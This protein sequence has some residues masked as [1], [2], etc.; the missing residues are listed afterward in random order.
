MPVSF[1]IGGSSHPIGGS[2]RPFPDFLLQELR[3]YADM[4]EKNPEMYEQL[5][6]QFAGMG[7]EGGPDIKDQPRH[8]RVKPRPGFVAKSKDEAGQKV[9]INLASHVKVPSQSW[10]VSSLEEGAFG[11]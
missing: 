8:V 5:Q 9:F 6:R 1:L 2:S 7:V 3:M 10:W 11:R 4:L